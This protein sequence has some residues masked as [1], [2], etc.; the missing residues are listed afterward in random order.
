MYVVSGCPRSGT[1]LMMDLMRVALGEDRLLGKK[2][3]Q[4]EQIEAIREQGEEES[5]A[6]YAARMYVF[7]KTRD[8]EKIMK[9]LEESKDMNPN[10]FW[11]MLYTVQGCHYRFFDADRLEEILS[12]EKPSVCKIVS[13]GLVGTDPRYITKMIYMIRHPRAVAKSQERLKRNYPFSDDG[14]F[15]VNGEEVKIHTPEMYINV[16]A[17]AARYLKKY[18]QIP[19][20]YVYFDDLISKPKETLDKVKEFL[21]E[22]DFD[23]AAAQIEPKL[24]RSEPEDIASP[25]WE[26][27]EFIYDHFCKQDFD[28]IQEY[29]KDQNRMIFRKNRRWLCVRMKTPKVEDECLN[30]MK[31]PIVRENYKKTAEKNKIDWRNEPC[32]F[33]CAHI[34]DSPKKTIEESIRENHWLSEEEV[35]ERKLKEVVSKIKPPEVELTL[36]EEPIR[37]PK[38]NTNIG[39]WDQVGDDSGDH[40]IPSAANSSEE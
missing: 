31:S 23:A 20:L 24:K 9:D 32:I 2:F 38:E 39:Y 30:C 21:G 4:E 10:G 26:D 11:E 37:P 25:F 3:P 6:Q 1:S 12:N 29:L 28:G 17:M 7:D 16:T 19:V 36:V 33:E 22:G 15:V 35:R 13:Q 5:D 34:V 8:E 14:K 27:A 40:M 18:D